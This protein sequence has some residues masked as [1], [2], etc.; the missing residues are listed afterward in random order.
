MSKNDMAETANDK[1]IAAIADFVIANGTENTF[2]GK[3]ITNF[4]DIPS[5]IATLDFIKD[6][7]EEISDALAVRDEV[8]DIEMDGDSFDIV[9]G[10]AYCPSLENEEDAALYEPPEEKGYVIVVCDGSDYYISNAEHIERNDNIYPW[11]Y[12]DDEEA[13]KG[14]ERDG[15]KLIYGMAGIDDGVYIDTPANRKLIENALQERIQ[16]ERKPSILEALKA[17]AEKSRQQQPKQDGKKSKE[18][19]M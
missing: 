12:Q 19:E 2:G 1:K 10:L 4:S 8:L 16:P 14:A 13:A 15:V 11:V 3:W 17:N 6:N 9:Y 7:A 18:M 5:D